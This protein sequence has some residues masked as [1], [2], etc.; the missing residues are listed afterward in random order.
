[1]N[2]K[3]IDMKSIKYTQIA[4][5]VPIFDTDEDAAHSGC[6]AEYIIIDGCLLKRK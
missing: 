4:R 5:D 3:M 1:M 2:V 6:E